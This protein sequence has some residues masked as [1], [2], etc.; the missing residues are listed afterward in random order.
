LSDNRTR[1]FIS[2]RWPL[3]IALWVAIS[4]NLAVI[5]VLWPKAQAVDF[6]VFWRAVHALHPY[7]LNEQPFVY[8]P[9]ALL[10]FWPL[11]AVDVWNG[12]L[13]WTAVS[14]AAF[15]I[16]ALRLYG[17]G[18]TMLALISPAVI[19]GVIPG[20]TSLIG[21]AILFAAFT[22]DCRWC[23]GILLGALMTF[24]PQ[25]AVMAP[26]FLLL[27]RDWLSVLALALTGAFIAALTTALFGGAI[28]RDWI[29]AIPGF[30]DI[31]ANRGLSMSAVSPAAFAKT[32]GLPSLPLLA[33]GCIAAIV[34]AVKSGA[35]NRQELPAMIAAASLFAAPYA[36]RY[37]MIAIAPAMA[38]VILSERSR[39][40]LL[41]CVAYSATFGPLSLAASTCLLDL[42]S[43]RAKSV[44]PT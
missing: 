4:S 28:W 35:L 16:A 32:I 9:T 42:R 1:S 5:A 39:K 33:L 44:Q 18:A 41:A 23:R 31:V 12:Y 43:S 27:R 22:T 37:D 38:A 6:A 24:K 25:L 21:S 26:L 2:D 36:L 15:M 3:L 30:Q 40:A 14:L 13:A 11:R 19:V 8:P 20:Q 34:I 29:D 17:R 7:A 10:W